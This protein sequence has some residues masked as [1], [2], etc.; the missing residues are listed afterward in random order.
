MTKF[1]VLVKT[2]LNQ[3]PAGHIL[4]MSSESSEIAKSNCKMSQIASLVSVLSVNLV[5]NVR[6]EGIS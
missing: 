6:D 5:Q 2:Y 4:R 3:R 1:S